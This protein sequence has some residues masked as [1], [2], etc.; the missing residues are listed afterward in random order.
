MAL[1]RHYK[2]E[3]EETGPE[4]MSPCDRGG[5]GCRNVATSQGTWAA[6]RSRKRHRTDPPWSL[7]REQTLPALE[8]VPVVWTETVRVCGFQLPACSPFVAAAPGDSIPGDPVAGLLLSPA[9]TCCGQLCPSSEPAHP[10]PEPP[11]AH[12]RC[13]L[14][15]GMAG[16]GVVLPAPRCLLTKVR[17]CSGV[18]GAAVPAVPRT[19]LRSLQPQ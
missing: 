10:H 2:W 11:H 12:C 9:Q 1:G 3:A 15:A 6:T 16:Q 18:S 19:A 4:K 14:G 7:W 8:S 17:A 5:R 13:F